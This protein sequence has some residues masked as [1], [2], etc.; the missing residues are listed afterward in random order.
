MFIKITDT[1]QNDVSSDSMFI[2]ITDTD[3]NSV[4]IQISVSDVNKHT[5]TG[6]ITIQISVSDVNKHT[7]TGY[8]ILIQCL[9]L[10]PHFLFS[11]P[12]FKSVP[13]PLVTLQVHFSL[14]Q[15]II[16]QSK[17]RDMVRGGSRTEFLGGH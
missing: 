10:L 3:L 15:W 6:Y 4:T 16:N 8:I 5:V 14:S 17:G 1:D 11:P 2:N 9:K 13:P 12:V 7:V